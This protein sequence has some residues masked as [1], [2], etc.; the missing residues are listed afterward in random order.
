MLGWPKAP[1][2]SGARV[3]AHNHGV[4][5][6]ATSPRS[7]RGLGLAF[8]SFSSLTGACSGLDNVLLRCNSLFT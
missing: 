1:A 7:P 8:V 4:A 5:W 3:R 6:P 2:R